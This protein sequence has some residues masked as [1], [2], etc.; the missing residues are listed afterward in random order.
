MATKF[1]RIDSSG[2][3]FEEQ[4]FNK[5]QS[6]NSSSAGVNHHFGI[7]DCKSQNPTDACSD[8]AGAILNTSGIHWAFVHNM[9]YMSGST[10]V[11][12]SMPA[13]IEKFNSIY[14]NFYLYETILF[15]I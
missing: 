7:K 11:S 2:T 14:H 8:D 4:I 13:D 15:Y 1:G 9:F 10:K 3:S 5:G 12:E 6:L